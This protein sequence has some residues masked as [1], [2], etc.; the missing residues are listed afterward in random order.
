MSALERIPDSSR[1]SR[2]VRKV[3]RPDA[4]WEV[5]DVQKAAEADT[6]GL[7]QFVSPSGTFVA[8]DTMSRIG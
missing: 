7:S 3:P 4:D 5:A 2:E 6:A 8:Y 1:A